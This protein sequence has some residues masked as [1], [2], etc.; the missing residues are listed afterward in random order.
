MGS[1]EE[2]IATRIDDLSSPNDSDKSL[3]VTRFL[4]APVQELLEEIDV[5]SRVLPQSVTGIQDMR[6]PQVYLGYAGP[7]ED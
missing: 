6:R 4:M 3:L 7:P 2:N 1:Q 5:E